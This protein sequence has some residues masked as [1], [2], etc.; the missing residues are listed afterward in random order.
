MK[1]SKSFWQLGF[2]SALKA[3]EDH[4][5]AQNK[6]V[7]NLLSKH[8]LLLPMEKET[9]SFANDAAGWEIQCA[10]LRADVERMNEKILKLEKSVD[11]LKNL[12]REAYEE[13]VSELDECGCPVCVADRGTLWAHSKARQK[14]QKLVEDAFREGVGGSD[15][16]ERSRYETTQK[17][18]QSEAFRTLNKTDNLNKP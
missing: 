5:R 11:N 18:L 16:I 14:L 13:G 10:G 6:L 2:D 1:Q 15:G 8:Q 17:W 9:E 12:I 3:E 4:R 7:R